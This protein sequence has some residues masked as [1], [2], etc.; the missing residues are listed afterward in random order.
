MFWL[1]SAC[2]AE[3]AVDT[4]LA[5][6]HD[7]AADTA[8]TSDTG[9]PGDSADTGDSGCTP[10][11][12]YAD[13]DHDGY[14]DPAARTE[15]C[16]APPGTVATAGDCDDDDA[17]VNPAAVETCND[18]DD[19]CD[20]TVDDDPADP[21]PYALAVSALGFGNTGR[22]LYVRAVDG[23]DG[24]LVLDAA[25]RE[26]LLGA[27][28]IWPDVLVADHTY[29]VSIFYD[30]DEDA[31]CEVFPD[32]SP[33]LGWVQGTGRVTGD[34][35]LLVVNTDAPETEACAVFGG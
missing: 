35:G 34:V 10:Q 17:A 31:V 14:G 29:A 22:L 9:A 15:S 1:L 24:T 18:V 27:D 30:R 8:D 20:G 19:D 3:P 32:A 2:T 11:P 26:A 6:G 25:M 5:I 23:A 12:W 4:A 7:S 28:K 13:L 21:G 33:D 16:D